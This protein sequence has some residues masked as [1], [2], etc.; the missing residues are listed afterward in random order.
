MI[1]RGEGG[2]ACG[3]IVL[4]IVDSVFPLFRDAI[5]TNL[6]YFVYYS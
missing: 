4:E 2:S 6:M 1:E 5:R 3:V